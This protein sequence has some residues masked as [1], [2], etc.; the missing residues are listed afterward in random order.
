MPALA[1]CTENTL[2]VSELVSERHLKNLGYN[3]FSI[4]VLSITA[5]TQIQSKS[6]GR[7]TAIQG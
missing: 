4:I 2:N 1:A 7:V 5:F 6:G 3:E